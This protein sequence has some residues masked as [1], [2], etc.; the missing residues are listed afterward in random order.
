MLGL[1]LYTCHSFHLK[2][3]LKRHLGIDQQRYRNLIYIQIDSYLQS[4]SYLYLSISEST[5]KYLNKNLNI[6]NAHMHRKYYIL[7]LLNQIPSDSK[8]PTLRDGGTLSLGHLG[9]RRSYTGHDLQCY[10]TSNQVFSLCQLPE[11][12]Y[13]LVRLDISEYV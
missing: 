2:M 11:I 5:Y 9:S 10:P 7:F 4:L 1:I 3:D 12:S 8:A 13:A 6:Q